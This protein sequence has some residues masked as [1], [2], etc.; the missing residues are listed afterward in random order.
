LRRL[1]LAAYFLEVGLLLVVLP[2]TAFWDRN[3]LFDLV[4]FV[5]AWLHNSY[6][7]GAVSGLGLLNIALGLS[8]ISGAVGAWLDR[9][10][11]AERADLAPPTGQ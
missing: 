10:G 11:T 9:S 8:E 1:L 3:Y 5:R 6:A 7:R 2:W 4:P